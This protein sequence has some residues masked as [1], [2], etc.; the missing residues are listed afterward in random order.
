METHQYRYYDV[1]ADAFIDMTEREMKAYARMKRIPKE[2][3]IQEMIRL[4]HNH[5]EIF[6]WSD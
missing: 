4:H 2:G 1:D 3:L 6:D 5:P